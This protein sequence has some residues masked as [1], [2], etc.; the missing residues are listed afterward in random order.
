MAGNRGKRIGIPIGAY[1][2]VTTPVQVF[3]RI[4][5][6]VW[7]NVEEVV[8]FDDASRDS[9]YKLAVGY[10]VLSENANPQ[11]LKNP[12]NLGYGGNRKAGYRYFMERGFDVVVLFHGDG[13]HAPEILARI[14]RPIVSGKADAVFGSRMLPAY[15][16]PLKGGMPAC[17]YVGNRVP[18]ALENRALGMGL[19]EFHGGYR[20]YN[21]HA[22]RQ[23]ELERMTDDFHI[24]TQIVIKMNH[25]G[26]QI[27]EAPIPT[28]YG[29]E[30][31]Y[32]NGWKYA[33]NALKAVYRYRRTVQSDKRCP[34]FSE[35][36][37]ATHPR[38]AGIRA[39]PTFTSLWEPIRMSSIAAAAKAIPPPNC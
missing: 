20:A 19:S 14:Y 16:G 28:C 17:K 15:G 3:R 13:Q 33:W 9:T 32:V 29:G 7:N 24:D 12:R 25:R 38:E 11:V 26:F 35:Y 4:P 5:A 30:I 36:F 2:A 27:S 37:C 39:T 21:L 22:L 1:N 10:K 23:I 31:C 8:V 34:E 6:A 18:T